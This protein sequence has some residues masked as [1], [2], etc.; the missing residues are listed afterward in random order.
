M[1]YDS[2]CVW[3]SNRPRLINGFNDS[4]FRFYSAK[5][6]ETATVS[7]T[8]PAP[9]AIVLEL[10]SDPTN[11][12]VVRHLTTPNVTYVALNYKN[13]D[14]RKL[15][16]WCGTYTGH[17]AILNTFMRV[18]HYWDK[19]EI[20]IDVAFGEGEHVAL[21]GRMNYRSTVLGKSVVSPMAIYAKVQN[22]KITYLQ[23]M[24]DTFA[25]AESFRSGGTW[26][27]RSN[28]HGKEVAVGDDAP[29]MGLFR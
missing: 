2:L 9:V 6:M 17:E 15:M 16:P 14:L 20:H 29:L 28:P 3:H 10:L 26:Y 23:Y 22:G 19:H 18:Q 5:P 1:P 4:R 21:F 11:P 7:A 24:E 13:E 25:T 8:T 12:E 27:F